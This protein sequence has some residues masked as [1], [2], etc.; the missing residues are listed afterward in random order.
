MQHVFDFARADFFAP[1]LDDVVTPGDEIEPAL[2]IGAEQ[3]ARIQ[4][5][6]AGNRPRAQTLCGLLR[7]AP[8]PAHHM[9]AANDQFAR[10]TPGQAAALVIDQPDLLVGHA[11]PHAAG[12]QVELFR[13]QIGHTLALGQPVH[14]EQHGLRKQC[15]DLCDLGLRQRCRGVGD[16]AQRGKVE[17]AQC[18]EIGQ[19][20]EHGGHAGE[21]GGPF[22]C[23][24]RQHLDRKG[25]R[26]LQQHR[27]AQAESHQHLIQPVVESERQGADDDVVLP[28]TQVAAHRTQR[29]EHVQ[30]GKHHALGIAGGARGI[31]DGGQILI[32]QVGMGG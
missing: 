19:Q 6:L 25:E 32:D 31:D 3:V 11:A 13:R 16:Q 4:H 29:G 12:A 7:L 27:G 28:Q 2:V 23:H 22:P 1:A 30:V 20:G 21:H 5:P 9:A 15:S 10:G 14:G 8:V 26:A 18:L 24:I 17:L